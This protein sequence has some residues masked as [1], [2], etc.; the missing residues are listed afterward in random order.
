MKKRQI[1]TLSLNIN[2]DDFNYGAVLHSWAFQQYLQNKL[3]EDIEIINYVTP[4]L[5]N[6]DRKRPLKD[7]IKKRKIK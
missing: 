2:T 5:E 3:N 7:A 1:G 4:R 6:N